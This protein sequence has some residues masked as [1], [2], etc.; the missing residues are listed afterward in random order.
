MSKKAAREYHLIC[1]TTGQSHGGFET[2]AGAPNMPARKAYKR[3]I[4]SME[5][6]SSNGMNR[7]DG[8]LRSKESSR[9]GGAPAPA[10]ID[11]R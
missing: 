4:F 10:A 3:G 1:R 11:V 2:L 7:N 9:N 5:T 8:N 6:Y